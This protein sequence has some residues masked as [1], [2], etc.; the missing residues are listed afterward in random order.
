M[1]SALRP[2]IRCCCD[3]KKPSDIP[4]ES[5]HGRKEDPG[6]TIRLNVSG[7][8]PR[9]SLGEFSLQPQQGAVRAIFVSLSF[10]QRELEQ[11]QKVNTILVA[12]RPTVS[13]TETLVRDK[14]TLEDLGLKLRQLDNSLSLES[15]SN[16]IGQR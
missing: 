6:K 15:N 2:A 1:S 14:A 11:Q 10:L 5:L 12:Q 7:A 13:E 16:M 4:V 3:S 9:T 8:L